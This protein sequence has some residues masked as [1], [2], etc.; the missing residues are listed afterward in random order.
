MAV[1]FFWATV[2][3]GDIIGA[4]GRDPLVPASIPIPEQQALAGASAL[5]AAAA[6]ASRARATEMDCRSTR[7]RRTVKPVKKP[8]ANKNLSVD[9][10]PR[11]QERQAEWRSEREAGRP[12]AQSTFDIRDHKHTAAPEDDSTRLSRR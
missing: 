12:S 10:L 1:V 4:P 11:R 9:G 8:A 7:M 5:Q 3:Y 6:G 2:L